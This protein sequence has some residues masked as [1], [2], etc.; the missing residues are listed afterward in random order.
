MIKGKKMG[1]A[2]WLRITRPFVRSPALDTRPF[3]HVD[4]ACLAGFLGL[5][6]TCNDVT[7]PTR[8]PPSV[9]VERCVD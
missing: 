2:T 3:L 1:V 7:F 5:Q 6:C 9:V 8:L 4:V